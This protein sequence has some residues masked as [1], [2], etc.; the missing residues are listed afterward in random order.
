MYSFN[1][2]TTLPLFV[3]LL[4]NELSSVDEHIINNYYDVQLKNTNFLDIVK[5][6]DYNDFMFV[7]NPLFSSYSNTLLNCCEYI[8]FDKEDECYIS[9]KDEK[10]EN[11][12]IEIKQINTNDEQSTVFKG[13]SPYEIAKHIVKKQKS[14][15]FIPLVIEKYTD[16]WSYHQTMFV[17][18]LLN[19]TSFLYDPNGYLSKYSNSC[20]HS[21]LS[22]Y[23]SIVNEIVC[24]INHTCKPIKYDLIQNR[25][26]NF[27]L[28]IVGS[29][30]CLICC[31]LFM[32]YYFHGY[33]I[34]NIDNYLSLKSKTI[35]TQHHIILYNAIGN[36]L[37]DIY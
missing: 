9:Y 34:E 8:E 36:A 5:C 17:I 11:F 30:N 29:G 10:P 19:N 31:V 33:S 1:M 7:I 4:T 2:E 3:S 16:K 37:H 28:P 23:I 22:R 13:Y 26:M 25:N 14:I 24:E 21:V 6:M 35:L 18:N 27:D 12:P 32:F 20:T 15:L